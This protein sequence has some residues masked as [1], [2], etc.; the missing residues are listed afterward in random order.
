LTTL[1]QTFV[2]TMSTA[3]KAI[4]PTST[5]SVWGVLPA[6]GHLDAYIAAV[7]RMPMLTHEEE[8]RYA[9]QLKNQNDLDAAGKLVM[10]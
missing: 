10:T 2:Y 7:N 8:L 3:I 5:P 6:L 1:I 4:Q 9:K